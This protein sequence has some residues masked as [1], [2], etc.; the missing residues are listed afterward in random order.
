MQRARQGLDLI[1]RRGFDRSRET[2]PRELR[3]EFE[4]PAEAFLDA[5]R[6]RLVTSG[7]ARERDPHFRK[8][9]EGLAGHL[10]RDLFEE[11]VQDLLQDAFPGLAGVHGGSDAGMDGAIADGAGEPYA[12]VVTTDESVIRNLT[13]SLRS[14]I[15]AGDVRRMAVLATSQAL[16]PQEARQPAPAEPES[17]GSSSSRSSIAGTSLRACIGTAGG[18]SSCLN[19]TGEPPALTAVPRTR[20]PLL[21]IE[22]VGRSADLAWLRETAGD[23]LLVGEPGSGKTSLLLQLVRDGRALFLADEG[24]FAGAFRD[25]RPEI[26]LVDDAHLD[27]ELL[28]RL[29]QLRRDIH[30]EGDFSIVATSW[31]GAR[32]EVADALGGLP[33]DRIRYLELLTRSEIVEVLRRIGLEEPDD[34]PYLAELVN[35]S[36]NRPGLAVTLGMSWLLGAQQ[37]VLTGQAILRFVVPFLKRVLDQDPTQLLAAFALG[38]DRGMSLSAVADF[39]G[40]PVGEVWNTLTRVGASGILAERRKDAFGDG[41]LAV[42]PS[43]LRV[44]LLQEV[45]FGT[46]RTTLGA[47]A[48]AGAKPDQR[49][50][51]SGLGSEPLRLRATA[52]VAQAVERGGLAS[53]LATVRLSGGVRGRMGARKLSGPDCGCRGGGSRRRAGAGNPSAIARS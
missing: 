26:V 21:D 39:L 40:V 42:Y 7:G 6:G 53:G 10:D 51:E 31:K 20:R 52:R 22:P 47:A 41:A 18:R 28:D 34:S 4:S 11:C 1:T 25:Q 2:Q 9:L 37:E 48:P 24:G 19:I 32:D 5:R 49:A 30:A 36:A 12:L 23:R 45:F 35:Q 38:G 17:L 33:N 15:E 13:G 44:P 14:R 43:T 8:I 27:P 3:A 16:T 46:V 29:R 50:R